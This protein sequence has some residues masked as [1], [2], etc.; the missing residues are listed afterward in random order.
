[1]RIMLIAAGIVVLASVP[2]QTA[3]AATVCAS[4]ATMEACIKCGAKKYGYDAQVR[5]CQANWRPGQK[6]EHISRKEMIRRYGK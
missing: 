5:H 2:V 4:L 1:M 3:R 6:T